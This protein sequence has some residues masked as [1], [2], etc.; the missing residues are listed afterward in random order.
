LRR[1]LYLTL[2]VPIAYL[3]L[4]Q[5]P[6]SLYAVVSG[7]M[8]PDIPRG[9]LVVV[10]AVPPVLGEAAAYRLEVDGRTYVLIHR[11]VGVR[12]GGYE[13]RAAAG[14]AVEIVPAGRVVGRVA[15]AVP[16]LGYLYMAGLANPLIAALLILVAL[17][18]P[19][20]PSSLL[21]LSL[22]TGAIAF[23]LPGRGLT[24]LMGPAPYLAYSAALASLLH[25]LE[26]R[27][28]PHQLIS[29]SHA[30]LIVMNASST[31]LGGVL[32]WLGAQP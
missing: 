23:A 24:A 10:E 26:R 2:I 5:P 7:S 32:R 17:M 12:D 19:G 11:V 25:L 9:S 20:R 8:E 28:G 22:A 27:V 4:Q 30:L 13:L 18:P 1:L 29:L 6:L 31:D 3:V 21:P 15:L 14:N 16:Y